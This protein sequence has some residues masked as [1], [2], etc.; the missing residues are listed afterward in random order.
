VDWVKLHTSYYD[1]ERIEVLDDAA[2][3]MFVRGLARAGELEREGFIPEKSLAKLTRRR[4]YAPLV[5]ELV[6]SGLWT[7]APGG[8]QV[9]NWDRWQDRLD[10]LAR[11]RAVDR[12][13][14]R[15]RRLRL[16]EQAESIASRDN[17]HSSRDGHGPKREEVEKEGGGGREV[18]P[19]ARDPAEPPPETCDRHPDGT[20]DPCR[21]CQR[22]REA[23]QRWQRDQA[24]AR[25]TA[26]RTARA[27]P[28]CDHCGNPTS[29]AYHRR[30]CATREDRP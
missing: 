9:A 10:D 14:Q 4:R 19:A 17:G 7:I 11:R 2:E 5:E 23:R 26:D 16:A 30:V 6:R 21:A 28:R 15:R 22:R 20:D 13:R 25:A 24:E 27:G 8:V 12:D 29:S 1:D 3:V 18:T